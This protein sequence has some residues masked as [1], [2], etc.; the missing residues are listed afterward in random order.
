MKQEFINSVNKITNYFGFSK[1]SISDYIE[2]QQNDTIGYINVEL[3]GILTSISFAATIKKEFS[4]LIN[5]DLNNDIDAL[6]EHF[7]MNYNITSKMQ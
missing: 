1:S 5:L 3:I 4:Y 6:N 7:V 2:T